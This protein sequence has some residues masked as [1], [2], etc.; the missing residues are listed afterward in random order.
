MFIFFTKLALY[1]FLFQGVATALAKA[2]AVP[3]PLAPQ[4]IAVG[5]FAPVFLILGL[6]RRE[7]K[8]SDVHILLIASGII[9][10]KAFGADIFGWRVD[11][12]QTFWYLSYIFLYVGLRDKNPLSVAD[13]TKSILWFGVF[14]ALVAILQCFGSEILPSYLVEPPFTREQLLTTIYSYE[15]VNA[16]MTRPNGLFSNPIVY[17]TF[18]VLVFE[19]ALLSFRKKQ[20][21]MI[22]LCILL[23]SVVI[24]IS[25]SRTAIVGF[26]LVSF[27][28]VLKFRKILFF[29][30]LL[31]SVAFIYSHFTESNSLTFEVLSRITERFTADDEFAQAS[32][33]EHLSDKESALKT[34]LSSPFIGYSFGFFAREDILTDGAAFILSLEFGIPITILLYVLVILQMRK[35]AKSPNYR[36]DFPFFSVYFFLISSLLNSSLIDKAIVPILIILLTISANRPTE[37][38]FAIRGMAEKKSG[39]SK[40]K[41]MYP[42]SM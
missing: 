17:S 6:A 19:V 9:L 10:T 26:F 18:L 22:C 8:K 36:G 29:A 31:V 39:S 32:N 20:T 12:T 1:A 21:L 2:V 38:Q 37:Q 41:G 7:L 28:Y 5:F 25:L 40:K 11:Y 24:F 30:A 35:M 42:C 33:L 23:V 3:L 14:S 16:I 34:I 15:M 4:T 13:V 27:A